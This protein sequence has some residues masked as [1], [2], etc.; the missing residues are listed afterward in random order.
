MRTLR[1]VKNR[2]FSIFAGLIGYLVLV[3]LA[4]TLFP[5][6]FRSAA[7]A[8]VFE[9]PWLALWTVLGAAGVAL[10]ERTGFPPAWS[11]GSFR[12]RL[13][14]P[15]L[16][17][18]GFGILA[19]V[20]DLVTGWTAVVA[21]KLGQPSIHIPFPASVAIYPG[22]A[23]IVEILYRL[24]LI[25][26]VLWIVSKVSRG[27]RGQKATFWV[28]AAL[29]SLAEPLGD[30]GLREQGFA[31]MA[32]VFVQDY[33]LNFTQAWFFRKRGLLAAIVVR[34]AFYVVWHVLPSLALSLGISR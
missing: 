10:S 33:A 23:I 16:V 9:W 6:A 5:T 20:T 19:V 8:K 14:S 34:V 17:G 24:F 31:T 7:Q 11:P 30:L 29:T 26:A 27:G 4:L 25:P 15:T 3:K 12:S 1:D 32:A 13:L 21:A 22:G 2:S 28:L 18:L